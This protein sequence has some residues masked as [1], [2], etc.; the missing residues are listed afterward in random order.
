MSHGQFSGEP[1]T[2][3]LTDKANPDRKMQVAEDFALELVAWKFDGQDIDRPENHDYL[4]KLRNA[5][6]TIREWSAV[7]V[8]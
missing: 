3:W 2:V 8:A 7:L 5:R 4:L 6:A 1:R